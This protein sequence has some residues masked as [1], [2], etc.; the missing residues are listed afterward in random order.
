[1]WVEIYLLS[2][3]VSISIVTPSRVCEL[4]SL[5]EPVWECSFVTPSRVCEL[6]YIPYQLQNQPSFCHTLTGVW[7]EIESLANYLNIATVTPS[8]VCELKFAPHCLTS[9]QLVSHPHGCVSWN[10]HLHRYK[11]AKYPV[12]P[13]RVCELK[14]WLLYCCYFRC[15][16]PS[17]VCELKYSLYSWNRNRID[18]HTLTGV[19]VEMPLLI[20]SLIAVS[21]TPSRVCELKYERRR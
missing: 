5:Q 15:V 16:T 21:V 3:V 11:S 18:R 14:Y 13:S 9:F 6:K 10:D 17:R 8:R 4:K 1:M 19:W 12:T 7:V 20:K 2:P